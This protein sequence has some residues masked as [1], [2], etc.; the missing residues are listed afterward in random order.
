MLLLTTVLA[1]A[2][3]GGG[4]DEVRE[5]GAPE[6]EL[7]G[8]TL[9]TGAGPDRWSLLTVPREGG[10]VRARA[11]ADPSR[12]V[13]EGSTR[14]PPAREVRLVEGPVVLLRADDG[15][16]RR[17][18]PRSDRLS[19]VAA[20]EGEARWSGWDRYG[21]WVQPDRSS[22]LEVGPEGSWR[23][24]LG[25]APRW[26]VPVR[27]GKVAV[28]VD[29]AE[30]AGL[31]LVARGGSEPESRARDGFAAPGLVTAWGRRVVLAGDGVV[32]F[33]AVPSLTSTGE[34]TVDGPVTAMTASPS[35]HEIYVAVDDPPRVMRVERF[36]MEAS[37]MAELA[38]PARGLRAAVLGEALL[39][40]DG[41]P[42]LRIPVGG[43]DTVRAVGEW[44]EDLPLA[45]PDGRVLAL[46][47]GTPVLWRADGTT[48][49]LEASGDR[50][51]AAVRWN[52]APPP[53][54]SDRVART[55]APAGTAGSEAAEPD[56]VEPA[57]DVRDTAGEA[58]APLSGA[59]PEAGFYA[60]VTAAREASGVRA[61][62]DRLGEAG[63]PTAL[64]AYRDDAGQR[65]YR[66]LVGPYRERRG[67]EAA[68]RQLRRERGTSAW[69][70]EVR[71]G[72]STEEIFR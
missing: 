29:E 14:L 36:G 32:R 54:V 16:V 71:A 58:E 4:P 27:E 7:A 46:R 44:R 41:G 65:W 61:L 9:L 13:W 72:A 26:A 24:E 17:Y 20:V 49:T 59:S 34:V 50:R 2:A 5:G 52:P 23:Y 38:R 40:D 66:G 53:V 10:V 45:L 43:D 39:V 37:Q 56:T 3:C 18:D 15:T 30:G 25:A 35:S 21:L 69:V 68:A 22:M 60:V 48:E 42:P 11:L 57:A 33:F 51:W 1:A 28:L 47:G 12:V 67:A 63:Y 31:W 19:R 70:T 6:M 62:L 64:Q 55:A 8:T